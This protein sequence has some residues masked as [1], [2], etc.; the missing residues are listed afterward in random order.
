M[1]KNEVSMVEVGF[2]CE[3][4]QE[5]ITGTTTLRKH[6][7]YQV[8]GLCNSLTCHC[9]LKEMQLISASFHQPEPSSSSPSFPAAPHICLSPSLGYYSG[10][11]ILQAIHGQH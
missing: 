4:G 11:Q 7:W 9:Q 3:K 2:V 5:H 6:G 10:S 8:L 1:N